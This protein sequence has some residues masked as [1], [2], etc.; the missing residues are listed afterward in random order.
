MRG[1]SS[2][3]FYR[4]LLTRQKKVK[5]AISKSECAVRTRSTISGSQTTY[6]VSPLF[7]GSQLTS[8]RYHV[9][10]EHVL[11][12]RRLL[13]TDDPSSSSSSLL[14]TEREF[15]DVA[16]ETLEGLQDAVEQALESSGI[17][18]QFEINLANGVLTLVLP[19][20]GTWVINKQTPNRQLWWSSPISGPRRYEYDEN[21]E[22]VYTRDESHSA[23]LFQ[24]LQEEV[25]HIYQVEIKLL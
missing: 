23:T 4:Q 24:T 3:A 21:D 22:W 20:H 11:S 16:D 17:Q 13:S 18:E 10:R 6:Q 7:R 25:H 2:C 1:S 15:H 19:P 9:P 14:A 12:Q 5:K 8:P